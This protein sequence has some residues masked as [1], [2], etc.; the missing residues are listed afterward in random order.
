MDSEFVK[1][2]VAADILNTTPE[3]ARVLV[4]H[5][6]VESKDGEQAINPKSGKKFGKPSKLYRRAQ[7]EKL[8]GLKIK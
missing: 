2:D 3:A 1:I 6:G 8:A 7:I 5:F 4:K